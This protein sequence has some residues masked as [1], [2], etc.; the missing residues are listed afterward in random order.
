M[1]KQNK[2]I[3]QE[4]KEKG[5][6][7]FAAGQYS[8]S[9]TWY[10][11]AIQ[12]DPTDH[13]LHSNRSA[14]HHGNKE[15]DKAVEAA[16]QCIKINAKWPKGYYRKAVAL[17][18]LNRYDD[19]IATLKKGLSYDASN[20][21]LQ[22]KLKEA[23]NKSKPQGLD[24]KAEGNA[25]FKESRYEKAIEAYTRALETIAEDSEKSIIF[26]NRAACYYQLR[27]YEEVVRDSTESLKLVPTNAKSL[28]R[29]GLAYESLEKQ[30]LALE[31]LQQVLALEPNTAVAAQAIN[32]IKAALARFEQRAN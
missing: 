1:S 3:A 12:A 29:R 11:K 31:D 32:R 6:K 5:N 4:H 21:D 22:N 26:S 24:A 9:L 17:M 27:S 30:K 13:V 23:Q 19:A 8:E 15:Y 25:H 18:S 20:A 7:L 10:I 28:L 14:A 16:D 2:Q